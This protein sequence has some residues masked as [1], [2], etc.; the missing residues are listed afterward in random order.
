MLWSRI[1]RLAPVRAL[2]AAL[3]VVAIGGAVALIGVTS[4]TEAAA[5]EVNADHAPGGQASETWRHGR[6]W[7][8]GWAH[9]RVTGVRFRTADGTRTKPTKP[10]RPVKPE[11]PGRPGTTTTAPTNGSIV[12]PPTTAPSTTDPSTTEPSMTEP[13]TTG[14][15]TTQLATTTT[16]PPATKPP[17]T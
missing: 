14:P 12:G 13:S 6:G 4:G 15:T 3:M 7:V 17:T 1:T 10:E 11:R 8:W 5:Q 9:Y 16:E 2:M